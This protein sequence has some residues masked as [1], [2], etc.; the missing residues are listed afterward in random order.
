MQSTLSEVWVLLIKFYLKIDDMFPLLSNVE[1]DWVTFLI[2]SL[3][4][5]LYN[6]IQYSFINRLDITQDL[7]RHTFGQF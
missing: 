1:T 3:L 4:Q 6:T 2:Y 5:V 7:K